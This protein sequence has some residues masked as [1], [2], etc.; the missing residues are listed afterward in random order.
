MKYIKSYT[1]YKDIRINEE[2]VGKSIKGSL[3]NLFQAFLTPFKDLSGNIK[4]YFN[5]NDPNS[6][7]SVILNTLNKAIDSAQKMI[8][9]N[10]MNDTKSVL[11]IFDQFKSELIE[12]SNG[13]G[14]DFKSAITDKYKSSAAYEIAKAILLGNKQANWKGIVGIISDDN[15]KYSS[16]NYIDLINKSIDGKPDDQQ[17]KISKDVAFKFFDDFQ[18]DISL[19]I[20][21]ELTKDEITK[22]YNDAKEK[23]G[24][25]KSLDYNKIKEF[26]DKKVKVLYKR[27]GYEDG[28]QPEDQKEKVGAKL[29]DKLDNN[30]NVFFKD[31]SGNEFKKS[32][33]DILGP[34]LDD[35]EKVQKDLSV[36]LGKLKV[37]TDKMKIVDDFVNILGDNNRQKDLQDIQRIMN[38]NSNQ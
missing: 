11:G 13:I 7:K 9:D 19:Q 15:Y 38:K 20:D 36:K 22:I 35:N 37:N 24:A 31:D 16:K 1:T 25:N 10:S 23:L 34:A 2:F 30:G 21:K 18:K 6:I 4:K 5:E 29:I 3:S 33:S 26:F 27:D 8:R 17:V 32:Y 12:I 14:P 28:K